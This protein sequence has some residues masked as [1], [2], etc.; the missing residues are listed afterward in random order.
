MRNNSKLPNIETSIF[1]I[2]GKMANEHNAINLAQGFPNF[3]SDPALIA[4]VDR[5]MQDGYNQ[6]APMAGDF[7]L[8]MEISKKIENL[9]NHFYDPESL[10]TIVISR[11]SRFLVEK[12]YRYN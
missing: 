3:P 1:S 5:A 4:L 2:M 11:A 12:S 10:H 9:H 6:Y 8:R 7:D